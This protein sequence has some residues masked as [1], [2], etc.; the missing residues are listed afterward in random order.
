MVRMLRHKQ[1]AGIMNT[2]NL[3]LRGLL[4][5]MAQINNTLVHKGLL[6]IDEIDDALA[7][8]ETSL[9]SEEGLFEDLSP[10]NRYAVC[11]PIRLLQAANHAQGE[12]D[13]PSFGELTRMVGKT[14]PS[15]D[16]ME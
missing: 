12:T 13:I 4:L 6:S 9:M 2:A 1:G 15:H 5:A 14:K 11:F 3:Q 7:K 16:P 8:A 10:A